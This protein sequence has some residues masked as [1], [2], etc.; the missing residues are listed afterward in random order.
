MAA[1]FAIAV[2]ALAAVLAG[3]GD[4]NGTPANSTPQPTSEATQDGTPGG[5]T[6]AGLVTPGDVVDENLAPVR[7]AR[8]DLARRFDARIEDI[9]IVSVEDREWPDTCLDVTYLGNTDEVCAPV[10]TPGY[11]IALRYGGNIVYYHASLDG[12]I[13]R[14]ADLDVGADGTP[15]PTPTNI[16]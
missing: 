5:P 3:C 6:P 12:A 13:L 8:E 9:A 4:D 15:Q 1:R 10:I 14:F 2:L 11:R 16:G 7:L